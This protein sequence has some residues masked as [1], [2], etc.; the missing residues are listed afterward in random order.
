MDR[1]ASGWGGAGWEV[2]ERLTLSLSRSLEDLPC[3]GQFRVCCGEELCCFLCELL[4]SFHSYILTWIIEAFFLSLLF[5]WRC[6]CEV[7]LGL[8]GWS[9]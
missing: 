1:G 8:T 3:N 7:A 5:T 9:Q 4:S 6:N 2:T